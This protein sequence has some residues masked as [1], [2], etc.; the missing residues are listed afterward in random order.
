MT[1]EEYQLSEDIFEIQRQQQEV[2]DQFFYEHC[3]YIAELEEQECHILKW[4]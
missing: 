4:F 3:D 2:F 1:Y